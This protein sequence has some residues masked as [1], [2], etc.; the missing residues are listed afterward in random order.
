MEVGMKFEETVERHRRMVREYL[1][2]L[3]GD[4]RFDANILRREMWTHDESKLKGMER[5]YYEQAHYCRNAEMSEHL[6]A[7]GRTL[8]CVRNEH[9]PE[10]WGRVS[11]GRCDARRMPL[12]Y[13]AIM[14]AD[15]A[16]RAKESGRDGEEWARAAW[17]EWLE[18][19]EEQKRVV[20]EVLRLCESG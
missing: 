8:H 6:I 5:A 14:A 17:R 4:E 11:G 7:S 19:S 20:V 12:T 15:W 2:R 9:H 18:M 3:T 16:A 1:E 13:V 10:F